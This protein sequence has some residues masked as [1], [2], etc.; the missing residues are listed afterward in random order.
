MSRTLKGNGI[1]LS[2]SA[3][4]TPLDP[5]RCRWQVSRLLLRQMRH[6]TAH[7]TNGGRIASRTSPTAAP[8]L[9]LLD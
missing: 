9:D 2:A 5:S 7:T 3:T 1:V 8:R 6:S 4:I